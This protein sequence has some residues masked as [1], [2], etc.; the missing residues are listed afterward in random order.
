VCGQQADAKTLLTHIAREIQKLSMELNKQTIGFGALS[1]EVES[2]TSK[3]RN[4][5]YV[6]EKCEEIAEYETEIAELKKKLG[7][8]QTKNVDKELNAVESSLR[9]DQYQLERMTRARERALELKKK[10]KQLERDLEKF[11]AL[12]AACSPAGIPAYVVARTIDAINDAAVAIIEDIGFWQALTV[13]LEANEQDCVE[14]WASVNGDPE[15]SVKGLST[16]ERE[17]VNLVIQ[18]ARRQVLDEM[19][20]LNYSFILVDEALDNLDAANMQKAISFFRRSNLQAL[21]VS[22]GEMRDA[23]PSFIVMKKKVA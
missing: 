12:Y 2:L 9:T 19:K 13:R 3:L 1:R 17:I 21:V 14:M 5:K 4:A 22:H 18:L 11:N 20:G 16:G 15:T 8:R 7:T 6:I 10:K 23:F